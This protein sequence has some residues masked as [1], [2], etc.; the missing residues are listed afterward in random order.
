MENSQQLKHKDARKA[1]AKDL[2]ILFTDPNG[3]VVL[4]EPAI[5]GIIELSNI[6]Y[7]GYFDST[8]VNSDCGCTSFY[9][10]NSE[11][12]VSEHGT[13]FVCKHLFGAAEIRGVKIE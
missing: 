7:F 9:H 12:Y 13:A 2:N 10:G 5:D 6:K 11:N 4:K 1:R 8:G 3:F